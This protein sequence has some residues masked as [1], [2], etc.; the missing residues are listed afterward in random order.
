[1]STPEVRIRT[2]LLWGFTCIALLS[3][4]APEAEAQVLYG[5]IVGDVK[6]ATGAFIPGAAIVVTNRGTNLTRQSITDEAG[7]Y[8]VADIPAGTYSVKV[9]QGGFKSF[10]RT[11]VTVSLNSVTRVDASLE[12][13]TI[14]QT[15]TVN[16]EPPVLQ[17]ETSEVH[18]ELVA[19]DLQNLPVPLG[20]NY[21]QIY[22]MLPGFAPPA[23]SHSIPT[24][25]A[26]SLE[27]TVN[28]T[29]NDQN[30]TRIDGVSTTHVQLPHVVSY[31]P[32][33]ES[34][35]EV[36]VVTNSMDAE[37][38]LAGGAAVNVQTRSGTN[39][40]HGSAFEYHSDQHLKAW[41]MRFDDAALNTGNKPK[42][43][44][45]EYGG[46]V[47]GPIKKNKAFYFVSYESTR[48]HENVNRTVTVPLPAMI[49]GDLALSGTP[50][51]DPLTGNPNNA[52]GRTQFAV[53][54]GDPNYSLC[55]QAA[56]P[57]CLNIIPA[58]RMDPIA[59]KILAFFPA[60]NLN[61]ENNNYFVSGPFAFDR[62]QVD[63][64]VDYN[65]NSKF[66]L[67]GTFGV[68]HYRTNVPTV[69]GEEGVG[70]PI[71]GSSN[72]GHGHGNTYWFTVMGT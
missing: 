13:G 65:V 5:S 9:S 55:N 67:I 49:K 52:T 36:N 38:G 2:V 21:Q 27:F 54:P 14:D 56:N 17:T 41:P 22:R 7:H 45:N 71:G 18:V 66:N 34:I 24:N 42:L 61:R 3:V 6:D 62:H 37:Q 57:Q 8:R 23:N 69:F 1:M 28:G 25:P 43:V 59:K 4:L 19:K 35:Q 32:T 44:Y 58:S 29:S 20:R 12:I 64:K 11:E 48:D 50:V 39:Q 51:Y 33:L 60:N 15:V 72:P 47:G 26:R 46:T 10:E 40:M 63:S 53:T 30:N 70:Q 68:L 31:I 16:A